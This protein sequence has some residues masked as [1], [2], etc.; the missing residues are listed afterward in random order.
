M[1]RRVTTL[2]IVLSLAA[3][4]SGG[5]D[6]AAS[7]RTAPA[8]TTTTRTPE[9]LA[10]EEK[11]AD[12]AL[13]KQL[14]RGLS[15]VWAAG[16][17]EGFAFVVAHNYPGL[18]YTADQCKRTA[19]AGGRV[20]EGYSEQHVVNEATIERDNGWRLRDTPLRGRALPGRIYA[21]QVTRTSTVADST[22]P[23][24]GPM[25]EEVHVAIRDGQ[26]Y[27]FVDCG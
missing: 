19:F 16:V 3:A 12:V 2:V 4:C 23:I 20:P 27:L 7:T 17:D 1:H 21:M 26:A 22:A 13:I 24:I 11:A 10:A 6:N 14:W 15:D 18:G 25:T 5:S 9:T 8:T